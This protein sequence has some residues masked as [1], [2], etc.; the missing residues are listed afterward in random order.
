LIFDLKIREE[1]CKGCG[2]CVYFCPKKVLDL[3]NKRNSHGYK[4]VFP[5]NPEK[6]NLCGIC[7][8]VCPDIVFVKDEK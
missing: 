5:K 6:C 7:Y 3:S 8:I 4:I 1:R 2:L